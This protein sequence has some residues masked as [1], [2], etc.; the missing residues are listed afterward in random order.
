MAETI[1]KTWC[2]DDVLSVRPNLTREQASA[3]LMH[4]R[5]THDATFEINLDVIEQAA[6]ELFEY[7]EDWCQT[8]LTKS[9]DK[10]V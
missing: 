7:R 4:L 2:V 10:P 9:G 6:D 5:E 3:L 8:L 1:N